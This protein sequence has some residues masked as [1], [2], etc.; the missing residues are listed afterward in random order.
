MRRAARTDSN[1]QE[2]TKAFRA[3]GFSVL[4][5]HILKNCGDIIIAKN[6]KTAIVEIKDGNKPPSAR[7][8]TKGES[9]FKT[10][11]NGDYFV[12]TCLDD[13]EEVAKKIACNI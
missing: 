5:I 2:I 12:V 13:V 8:L 9:C 3:L 1:H 11:W 7:K 10:S 4:D 6:R